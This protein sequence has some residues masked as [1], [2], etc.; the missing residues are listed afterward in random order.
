MA[1]EAGHS[2]LGASGA[3]R[4]MACPGSVGLSRGIVDEESDHA[5]LGTAAH[6]LGALCLEQNRDAWTFIGHFVGDGTAHYDSEGPVTGMK[7]VDKDM[8]DAV[9]VYLDT[10]R[11]SHPNRNQGNTW[12]ERP[13]HCPDIHQYFYGTAD[14]VHL[15]GDV[16]YVTDYKHGAGIV[17][18][19]ERNPQLM[20]YAVGAIDSLGLWDKVDRV[21]LRIVQPRGFHFDGPVREWTVDLVALSQWLEDELV[22]AM[23]RA[24]SSNATKSGEHCRFCPVR[25]RACPQILKDAEELERI[26][27]QMGDDMEKGAA[28][29]SNDQVA[30][31][32]DLYDVF[33]IAATAASKTAF[34]RM[35]NGH[36]ILGRKL[37]K[38]KKNRAWKE[39]AEA[40]LKAKYGDKAFTE[41]TLKSPAEIDKMAQGKALTARYAFK[42]EGDLTVV[43]GDDTRAAI[44]RDTKSLFKPV[45]K[46]AA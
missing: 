22:P 16:L 4:W 33:K 42:P 40:A 37:V 6:T 31:F 9:Q 7:Y 10:L 19:V 28:E 27:A 23:D 14:F 35:S 45:G 20:Y 44:S 26:V 3:Y 11:T 21:V 29:L 30:R 25:G 32:L 15:D 38:A 13:F 41:P 24:M 17:V 5:A 8:A 12:I 1:S 36:T 39:D 46:A 34:H 18:E 43:K 2:P